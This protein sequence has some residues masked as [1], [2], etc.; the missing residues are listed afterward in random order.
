MNTC[1]HLDRYITCLVNI[2]DADVSAQGASAAAIL[3]TRNNAFRRFWQIKWLNQE[4]ELIA[5][6]STC[7]G[8]EIQVKHT[9]CACSIFYLLE[10][11]QK[12]WYV[13]NNG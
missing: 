12:P 7:R 5:S 6:H 4:R 13:I 1:Y 3:T 8:L 2:V 11:I 9:R 10:K